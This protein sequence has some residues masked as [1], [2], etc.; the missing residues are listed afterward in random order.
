[1]M[2]DIKLIGLGYEC[3][4]MTGRFNSISILLEMQTGWPT[5]D[6]LYS[7][8]ITIDKKFLHLI[9]EGRNYR[10]AKSW[11]IAPNVRIQCHDI[12]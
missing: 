5:L 12:L 4:H 8:V 1:M 6:Q 9:E 10:P 11:G 7:A 3:H 2:N